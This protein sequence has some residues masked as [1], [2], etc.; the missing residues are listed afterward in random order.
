MVQRV[1]AVEG[2]IGPVPSHV[3]LLPLFLSWVRAVTFYSLQV[4]VI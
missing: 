2:L 3:Y 1:H 4:S